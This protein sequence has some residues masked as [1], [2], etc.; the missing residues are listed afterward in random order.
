MRCNFF[1]FIVL[2]NELVPIFRTGVRNLETGS[3]GKTIKPE[4]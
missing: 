3:F 4:I 1:L 2:S